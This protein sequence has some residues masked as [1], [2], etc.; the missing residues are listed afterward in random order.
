MLRGLNGKTRTDRDT[1]MY[2]SCLEF[3]F[4][5]G[6]YPAHRNEVVWIY[7]AKRERKCHFF[8]VD[9]KHKRRPL[10]LWIQVVSDY[11]NQPGLTTYLALN[12]NE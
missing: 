11:M 5:S 8:T 6:N 1:H 2:S 12:R 10:N 4:D 9:G 3:L 7:N